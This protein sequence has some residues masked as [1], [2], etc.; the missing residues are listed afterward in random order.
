MS[1]SEVWPPLECKGYQILFFDQNTVI[2]KNE[3]GRPFVDPS[4]NYSTDNRDEILA[5]DREGHTISATASTT[6]E[7]RIIGEITFGLGGR[8]DADSYEDMAHQIEVYVAGFG[9]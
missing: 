2:F 8:I 1:G 7:G 4:N 3:I 5:F 6:A 9:G